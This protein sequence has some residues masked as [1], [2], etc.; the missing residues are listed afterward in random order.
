MNR[1]DDWYKMIIPTDKCITKIK[2]KEYL[3]IEIGWDCGNKECPVC[4]ALSQ[5]IPVG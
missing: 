3:N 5:P 1:V 4:F 2:L